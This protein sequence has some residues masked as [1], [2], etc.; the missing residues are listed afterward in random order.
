MVLTAERRR[1]LLDIVTVTDSARTT[2][3]AAALNVSAVTVRADLAYLERQGKIRRTH[4]GAVATT[5][6]ELTASFVTRAQRNAS[7]KRRIAHAAATLIGPGQAIIVDAGTTMFALA[8]AM[9]AA[10]GLT[11]F[12]HGINVAQQFASIDGVEVHVL[13]G[14]LSADNMETIGTGHDNDL[15]NVIAHYAFLGAGGV[16]ADLDIT[17]SSFALVTSKRNMLK[18]ARR[19]VLLADSSKWTTQ[20]R[21]K[22]APISTFD[23]VITDTDLPEQTQSRLRTLGLDLRVV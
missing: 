19:K 15:D 8:Q 14:V 13:G 16:D 17:E 10:P 6:G 5:Q 22:A 9:G 12:T 7:A 23:I 21:V 1:R 4:G 11:V 3:L 2:E 18:A 20:V